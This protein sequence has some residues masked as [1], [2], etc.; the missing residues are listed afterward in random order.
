MKKFSK[1][2]SGFT[3][4]E[5]IIVMAIFS[6]L[7]VGAISL[8]GP[9][10]RI[11]KTTSNSEKIGSYINTAQQYVEDSLKFSEYLWIYT[12]LDEANIEREVENYFDTFY[13][14]IIRFD[15]KNPE[16][17]EGNIRV[18]CLENNNGGQITMTEYGFANNSLKTPIGPNDQLPQAFF[19]RPTTR[20]ENFFK[21]SL[22]VNELVK[23]NDATGERVYSLSNDKN[24]T[25]ITGTDVTKMNLTLSVLAAQE[26]T[27]KIAGT[28][29][30]YSTFA[31]PTQISVASIPLMN[32][33]YNSTLT[34]LKLQPTKTL[35]NLKAAGHN[36][37]VSS[38]LAKV[39]SRT[40]TSTYSYMLLE[41]AFDPADR[42]VGATK[43]DF[44][45]LDKN[46]YFIYSYVDEITA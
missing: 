9:V 13:K 21:Y 4:V 34:R 20:V 2:I 3:L 18:M 15:G 38:G 11:F 6:I 16:F 23:T 8:I 43:T 19:T 22:G 27:G 5:L 44:Q 30:S 42:V 41:D 26:D 46:I 37:W 7:L 35:N 32:I 29:Y 39:V 33:N 31:I 10:Q 40:D 14:D 24:N 45:D 25:Q 1:R 36:E 28:D 17:I 12:D